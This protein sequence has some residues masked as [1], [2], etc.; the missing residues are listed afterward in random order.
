MRIRSRFWRSIKKLFS[1]CVYR[2]L[3]FFLPHRRK[4]ECQADMAIVC[5]ASLG[6]F[7]TFCAVAK[8]LRLQ[9][10]TMV[11]VCK[12]G[13]GIEE[14][15]DMTGYFQKIYPI[16]KNKNQEKRGNLF[17]FFALS[18]I[19][20]NKAKLQTQFADIVKWSHRTRQEIII[21]EMESFYH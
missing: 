18:C 3:L 14:F 11:L 9:G 19:I 5:M 10:R 4:G 17:S 15:A 8:C 20:K 21:Y 7:I 12:K 13:C 6:D 16:M 2:P 1:Y